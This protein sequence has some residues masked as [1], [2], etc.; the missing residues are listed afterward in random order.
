LGGGAVSAYHHVS[1]EYAM[2]KAAEMGWLN[3]EKPLT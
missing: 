3:E 2:I 1:G